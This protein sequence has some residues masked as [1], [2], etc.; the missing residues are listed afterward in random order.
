[1]ARCAPPRAA[2]GCGPG[3]CRA[4]VCRRRWRPRS[5]SG[6]RSGR[7]RFGAT[8]GVGGEDRHDLFTTGLA[9]EDGA[10]F[11]VAERAVPDR[12][13]D[14]DL[15]GV[16]AAV[17]RDRDLPPG[18]GRGDLGRGAQPVALQPGAA[19]FA[20]AGWGGCG[21]RGVGRQPGGD[22]G[23]LDQQRL[24]VVGGVT[25]RVDTPVRKLL[26][27]R[28]RISSRQAAADDPR[29]LRRVIVDAI[30]Y[31]VR[32]GITWRQR[33]VQFPPAATVYAV[34]ARWARSGA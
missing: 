17:A 23:A 28:R 6:R 14:G 22:G 31:V 13:D 19:A 29:A 12:I 16:A 26:G 27:A 34:F 10:A 4:V 9:D 33:P 2:A 25:D 7:P 1:M 5:A 32:G 18:R 24:A 15:H 21:Q 8:G 3:R 11:G 20:G 30:L